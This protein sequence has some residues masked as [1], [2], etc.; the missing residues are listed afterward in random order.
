MQRLE[1]QIGTALLQHNGRGR[2]LTEA[3]EK[4]VGHA[5]RILTT[6]KEA[7]LSISGAIAEGQVSLGLTQDFADSDLPPLLSAFAKSHSRIRCKLVVGRSSELLQQL[8]SG[9]LDV[10]IVMDTAESRDALARIIEP[11]CW[12]CARDGL[13][14]S[15]SEL[16]LALLDAPCGFRDAALNALG[17]AGRNYWI[18]ASSSGL[19]GLRVA[20][21][22]GIASVRTPRWAG[23]DLVVA[24][25]KWQLPKLPNATFSIRI[26][27]NGGG[28][29]KALATL[30]AE[31]LRAF[32]H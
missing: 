19:A 14:T 27:K 29:A 9:Q 3:G 18:A 16:P 24:P 26:S 20:V 15:E 8:D 17:A 31:G 7:W 2:S 1:V 30:L 28:A 10:A 32:Q 21:S 12:L 23:T 22:S 13:V 25:K 11:M 6:H 5:Q 4:L